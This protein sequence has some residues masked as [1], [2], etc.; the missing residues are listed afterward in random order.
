[1]QSIID[2]FGNDAFIDT[3]EVYGF[4]K[5]EEFLGE[6]IKVGLSTPSLRSHG[7]LLPGST[8]GYQLIMIEPEGGNRIPKG[9][10]CSPEGYPCL[11]IQMRERG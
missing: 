8:T 4:G 10:L 3:A 2:V 1:M 7:D 6:F 5:S 9:G 11:Y